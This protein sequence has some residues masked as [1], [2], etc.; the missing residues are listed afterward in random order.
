MLLLIYTEAQRVSVIVVRWW[1]DLTEVDLDL[2]L[3]LVTGR[4]T[5]KDSVFSKDL[6]WFQALLRFG[7]PRSH[8]WPPSLRVQ[9]LS[10][11]RPDYLEMRFARNG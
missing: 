11:G 9:R 7:A 1:R 10:R 4:K 8:G 2:D 5:V 6:S 3:T